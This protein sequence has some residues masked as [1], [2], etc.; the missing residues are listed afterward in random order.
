VNEKPLDPLTLIVTLDHEGKASG[1]MYEDAGDGYG[2]QAG[3]F[4]MSRY[5]ASTEGDTVVVT[6][7]GS[8]GKMARPNRKVIVRLLLSDRE[9]LAEGVDGQPV[10]VP[11]K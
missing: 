1:T 2:Y 11:L 4:L 5:S 6:L 8:E 10:R 3:E 7:A 9:V